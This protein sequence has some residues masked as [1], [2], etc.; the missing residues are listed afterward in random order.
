VALLRGLHLSRGRSQSQP[1]VAT[2]GSQRAM[3]Q[4]C[5]NQAA[6]V[7]P[8]AVLDT[9]D[10][11]LPE[12][13]R[14]QFVPPIRHVKP[15]NPYLPLLTPMMLVEISAAFRKFDRDGDGHIEP[16]EMRTVMSNLGVHMSDEAVKKI[17][18]NVDTN[19]D[20]VIEFD[21]FIGIMGRRILNE[22][23]EFEHALSIF[24]TAGD[25][26][27][28]PKRVVHMDDIRDI[29]SKMGDNPLSKDEVDA[30]LASLHPD[31]DGYVSREQFKEAPFWKLKMPPSE[32][33]GGRKRASA[34]AGGS[35]T[36]GPPVSSVSR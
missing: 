20:G 1:R 10:S 16:H 23:A 13:L 15:D 22:G 27:G 30:M 7:G 9:N 31:Q 25:D 2:R 34:D 3:G 29:M 35:R 26:D 11:R 5:S 4:I 14:T 21:E 19:D 24:F 12:I 6:K 32:G 17:I 36:G 18:A 28:E 8:D 33:G